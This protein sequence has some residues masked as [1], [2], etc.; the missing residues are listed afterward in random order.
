MEKVRVK[1]CCE[2]LLLVSARFSLV[3]LDKQAQASE[4]IKP[5]LLLLSSIRALHQRGGIHG[6]LNTMLVMM[7]VML[8][9]SVNKK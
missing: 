3:Q 5:F 6:C 7:K 8:V 2:W 4:A 1:T 9:L